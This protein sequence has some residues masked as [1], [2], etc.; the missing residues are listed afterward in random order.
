MT[1]TNTVKVLLVS[2]GALVV[3]AC[4]NPQAAEEA[5]AAALPKVS[6]AQ[7]VHERITE[8]DEFTGRLQA[9]QTVHLIPRVSGYIEKVHFN[10]GALVN[11]GDLLVQIDPRHFATEVARLEAELNSA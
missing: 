10:E 6:V 4:S 8:W 11:K 2:I 1:M 9:P 5:P 3:A 7:V